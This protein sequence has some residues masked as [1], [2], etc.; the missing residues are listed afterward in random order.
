MSRRI[1]RGIGALVLAAALGVA[2]CFSDAIKQNQEM[3]EQQKA[4]LDQL[5]QQIAELKAAQQRPYPTTSPAPGSCDKGVMEQATKRGG[6]QF[7]TGQFDKALGYYQDAVTAC[8]SSAQAELNLARTYEA[9]KNR[10][11]A[12]VYY[13]RA[14]STA[15]SEKGSSTTVSEQ[16]RQALARLTAK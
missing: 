4:E 7:A 12:M 3:L 9:L 14:L 10:D 1:Y 16:A 11:Q 15:A 6:E 13:R 5:Q 2:G 8:P